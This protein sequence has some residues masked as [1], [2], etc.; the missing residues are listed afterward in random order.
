M[1]TQKR[2]PTKESLKR[3]PIVGAQPKDEKEEKHLKEIKKFKFINT[4]NPGL[5]HPFSYGSGK[6]SQSFCFVDG[7]EYEIP[8]HVARWMDDC[9]VPQY[10]WRP[11]GDGRMQKSLTGYTHRFQMREVY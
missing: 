8:R 7:A 4:E 2:A 5:I 6:Y 10:K 3:L 11:G 1:I 9:K